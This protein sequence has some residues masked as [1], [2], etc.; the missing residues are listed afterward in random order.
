[1]LGELVRRLDGG[2]PADAARVLQQFLVDHAGSPRV[3]EALALMVRALH[4]RKSFGPAY[5]A[6]LR[7][8][9]RFGDQ[10]VTRADGARVAARAFVEEW[11]ARDPYPA[12]ARSAQRRDL[13]PDLEL[14]FERAFPNENFLDVPDLLGQRPEPLRHAILVRA[15][16]RVLTLDARDGNE[17]YRIDFRRGEPK[18]PLVFAGERLHAVTDQHIHVFDARTGRALHERRLPSNGR[19]ERLL[20]HQG[21]IFL[22]FRQR[23]LR[24]QVGLAALHPDDGSVLWSRVFD[25]GG[26]DPRMATYQAIALADRLLLFATHPV[27]LTSIDPTSGAVENSITLDRERGTTLVEPIVLPDGRILVGLGTAQPLPRFEYKHSYTLALVDPASP[28]PI[29]KEEAPHDGKSR[30][31]HMLGVVG[32]HVV[33]LDDARGS[34]VYDLESGR[35]LKWAP[36]LELSDETGDRP[37]LDHPQPRHDSLL[38]VLTRS[39]ELGDQPARL[40]AFELPDLRRKYTLPLTEGGAQ[41]AS[42]IPAEGVLG[43]KIWS[44]RRSTPQ[45]R[46]RLVDPLHGRA[47]REILPPARNVE[48]INAKVQNG[49]LVVTTSANVVYA[50]GPGG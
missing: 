24:G 1:V 30:Y 5:G 33:A 35:L 38:L 15:H 23:S 14:R 40:T 47:L 37:Y 27:T 17:L 36:E 45:P 22:L 10:L 4:E 28:S 2:A 48:W 29:W 39:R 18:G 7:L 50:Y 6:L 42:L 34:A 12:L 3:P 19:A 20:E 44:R 26:M 31:L 49:I 13:D 46:I 9:T 16:R 32:K 41:T 11:L 8:R 43:L 25:E 21:Q